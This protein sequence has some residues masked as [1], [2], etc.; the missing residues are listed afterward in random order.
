MASISRQVD[1]NPISRDTDS[2]ENASI[3][4]LIY[5]TTAIERE[6]FFREI[7]SIRIARQSILDDHP[8]EIEKNEI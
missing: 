8:F 3:Q 4:L 7:E 2:L 5:L 6:G 1:K